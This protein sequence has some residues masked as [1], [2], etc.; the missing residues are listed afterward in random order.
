M[1]AGGSIVDASSFSKLGK[2]SVS[3]ALDSILRQMK[4]GDV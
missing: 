4:G 1:V 2:A 3:S